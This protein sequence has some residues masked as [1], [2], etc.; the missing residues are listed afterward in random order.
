MNTVGGEAQIVH[1][2][3]FEISTT[4]NFLFQVQNKF[5]VSTV[6]K[7]VIGKKRILT[8]AGLLLNPQKN[9]LKLCVKTSDRET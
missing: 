1:W 9:G 4:V 3:T 2:K 6:S 7:L 8:S 5:T